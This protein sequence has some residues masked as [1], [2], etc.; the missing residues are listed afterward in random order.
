MHQAWA[1][2]L[3]S[4]H[5]EGEVHRKSNQKNT[6]F[7]CCK[8]DR[9]VSSSRGQR[10]LLDFSIPGAW[11]RLFLLCHSGCRIRIRQSASRNSDYGRENAAGVPVSFGGSEHGRKGGNGKGGKS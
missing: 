11:H 6:N 7:R 2:F 3:R 9:Y 8:E 5:A 1:Q 4:L 10:S